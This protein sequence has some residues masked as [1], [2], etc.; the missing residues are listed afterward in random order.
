MLHAVIARL[1]D[2]SV[3]TPATGPF[4][5][6]LDGRDDEGLMT[7]VWLQRPPAAGTS[8]VLPASFRHVAITEFMAESAAVRVY[9]LATDAGDFR[10]RATAAFVHRDA[11]ALVHRAVPPRRAPWLRRMLWSAL[12]GIMAVP[13]ARQLLLAVRKR[14]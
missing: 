4:A 1:T 14:R 7:R 12:P 6:V 3:S 13:F 9:G 5:L 8:P 11:S 2:V 10:W